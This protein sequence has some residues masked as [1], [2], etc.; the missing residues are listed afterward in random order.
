MTNTYRAV[1]GYGK[2]IY[3][4]EVFEGDFT[5]AEERDHLE[6]KHLELVSR[7]YRVLSDNFA[8]GEQGSEIE[9]AYPVEIEAALSGVHIERVKAPLAEEAPKGNASREEWAA[10]AAGKGASDEELQAV[11]DGGSSRDE[12]RAKYGAPDE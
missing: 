3:G 8:A 1:S 11:E 10:F 2:A 12:L 6:G 7:K 9:A 4:E 5:A